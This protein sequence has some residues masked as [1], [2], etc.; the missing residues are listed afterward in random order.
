MKATELRKLDQKSLQV[1]LEKARQELFLAKF[2]VASGESNNTAAIQRG[3]II[4]ARILTIMNE[5]GVQADVQE[6]KLEKTN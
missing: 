5:K 6:E 3:K 4:V 1:E 2:K